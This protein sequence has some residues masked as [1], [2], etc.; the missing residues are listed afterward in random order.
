MNGLPQALIKPLVM[1]LWLNCYK[2]IHMT[3]ICFTR[4]CTILWLRL[5]Q[6]FH[7]EDILVKVSNFSNPDV[8]NR[9]D[10]NEKSVCLHA[11][12]EELT[13]KTQPERTGVCLW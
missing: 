10:E 5:L 2:E 3:N 11:H 1:K 12:I 6:L 7:V 9:V 8:Y 13:V 4:L